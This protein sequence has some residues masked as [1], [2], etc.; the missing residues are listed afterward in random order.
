M[1]FG[2]T[3]DRLYLTIF[4]DK[5]NILRVDKFQYF[6]FSSHNMFFEFINSNFL[7]SVIIVISNYWSVSIAACLSSFVRLFTGRFAK[8]SFDCESQ[9]VVTK[10][11]PL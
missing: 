1:T 3:K 6:Q 2:S 5:L 8:E 4:D 11:I 9:F 7:N 10:T